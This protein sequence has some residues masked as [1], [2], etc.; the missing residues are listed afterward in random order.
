M[1][2]RPPRSTHCIS[3]AA[4]DVYKRQGLDVG[5]AA[6][7]RD[8]WQRLPQQQ[9]RAIS[10]S[11]IRYFSDR[12]WDRPFQELSSARGKPSPGMVSAGTRTMGAENKHPKNTQR[13]RTSLFFFRC[14]WLHFLVASLDG[15]LTR[16]KGGVLNLANMR[17]HHARRNLFSCPVRCILH[18]VLVSRHVR[19]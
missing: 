2:R 8:R 4:S 15:S 14:P 7:G 5:S 18:P 13:L 11:E 10:L 19:G 9:Q 17:R 3:S 12:S 1:I 16:A 6:W